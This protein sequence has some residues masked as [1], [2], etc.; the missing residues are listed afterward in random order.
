MLFCIA[1]VAFFNYVLIYGIWIFPK[2]EWSALGT[3]LSR[4]N[5]GGFYALFDENADLKKILQEF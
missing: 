5:D 2:L 3:V 4:I 1:N